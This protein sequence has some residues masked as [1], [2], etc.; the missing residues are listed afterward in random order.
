MGI[1]NITPTGEK[2]TCLAGEK[3]KFQFSLANVSGGP[4]RV[5][6]DVR[7]DGD[8]GT[9]LSVEGAIER[10]LSEGVSTTVNVEIAPPKNLLKPN[11]PDK[12]VTFR[13][14]VYDAQN[15]ETVEDSSTVSVV[16]QPGKEEDKKCLWCWLAPLI[17]VVVIGIGGIIWL[18]LQPDTY[19]DIVGKKASE[20]KIRLEDENYE[21]SWF[22]VV[23]DKSPGIIVD[24]SPKAGEPLPKLE[25]NAAIP[26]DITIS[27]ITVTMPNIVGKSVADAELVLDTLGLVIGEI[28]EQDSATRGLDSALV[29]GQEPEAS[30]PILPG[31]KV[32]LL[33]PS[34]S[35]LIPNVA[36]FSYREAKTTLEQLG[37]RVRAQYVSTGQAELGVVISHNPLADTKAKIGSSI[38]LKVEKTKVRIPNVVGKSPSAAIRELKNL[39]LKVKSVYR[40][41]VI[42]N[43]DFKIIKQSIGAGKTVDIGKTITLTYPKAKSTI[44]MHDFKIAPSV[45]FKVK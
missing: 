16:V 12:T 33:I 11:D 44:L 3:T 5:G 21:I 17:A 6:L 41:R 34:Q 20:E 14:R 29:V 2:M 39:G 45:L 40:G 26:I 25:G 38:T 28:L 19:P 13:L 7:V 30:T 23:S 10:D 32:N 31:T 37:L 1:V 15:T 22:E 4:L 42:K 8:A 36:G 43:G 9:W 18:V 27:A 24:Q 35:V